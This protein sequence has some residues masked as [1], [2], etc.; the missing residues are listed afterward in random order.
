MIFVNDNLNDYYFCWR[1]LFF[2]KDGDILRRT[3]SDKP[4]WL[5]FCCD[6]L[7][8]HL[9]KNCLPQIKNGID[10]YSKF[11]ENVILSGDFSSEIFERHMKSS[12]AIHHLKGLITKILI[13]QL[14]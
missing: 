6:N 12:C 5:L 8:K 2:S 4:K 9:I 7:Y 14:V 13:I 3:T 11:Y 10:F 1:L